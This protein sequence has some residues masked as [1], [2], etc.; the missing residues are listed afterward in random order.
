VGVF[1]KISIGVLKLFL[2][3][4]HPDSM[5]GDYEEEYLE[6]KRERGAFH[7]I[8]WL[9][10]EIIYLIPNYFNNS[11]FWSLVMLRNYLKIALRIIMRQKVYSF[12]NISGLAVGLASCILIMLWVQNELSFDRF[13]E[14]SENTYIIYNY[15]TYSDGA[16]DYW[17]QSPAP[18]KENLKKDFPE[19]S[20]IV[21][22]RRNGAVLRYND[23][24][25]KESNLQFVDAGFF[26]L[27]SF[28]LIQGD[29]E[30]CLLDPHSIVLT[31][32]MAEKYFGTENPIGK[33]VRLNDEL[34]LTVTGVAEECPSNSSIKF[35]FLVPFV[36]LKQLG[37][38]LESWGNW[39]YFYYVNIDENV[40]KAE[41]KEKIHHYY[42]QVFANQRDSNPPY[43][44]FMPFKD[45]YLYSSHILGGWIKGDVTYIYIFSAIA[46]FILLTACINFMNLATARSVNRAREVGLRKVVGAKRINVISQF[47][48]ESSFVALL[49]LILSFGIVAISLPFFNDLTSKELSF[50]M[51]LK[52]NI[53][54]VLFIT[55]TITSIISG[56]YPAIFLSSFQ[57][58]K[59][60]KGSLKAGAGNSLFRKVL[61]SLQFVLTIG[62]I[63]GAIVINQQLRFVRT[64]NMG[65]EKEHLITISIPRN[66]RSSLEALKN[67]FSQLTGVKNMT[68]TSSFPSGGMSS[69]S[70]FDWE[71]RT[72]DEE[73]NCFIL[74][75]DKEYAKTFGLEIVDG[76]F[77]SEE[78]TADSVGSL[79]VNETFV[80]ATGM[81]NPLGKMVAGDRLVGI[82][83]DYHFQSLHEPIAPLMIANVEDYDFIVLK[84]HPTSILNTIAG[85][86]AIWKEKTNDS[87]FEYEFLDER[88]NN[89]YKNDEKVEATINVFTILILF[90]ASLGLFGLSSF[91]AEQ[92]RKEVGIRKVMGASVSGLFF[93]MVRDYAKWIVLANVI[94]WPTAYFL[95]SKWLEGFAYRIDIPLIVFPLAG[96]L[97]LLIAVFSVGYQSISAATS[98][99]IDSIKY[100]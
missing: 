38:D 26:S 20:E 85:L 49:S 36:T 7:A 19:F 42:K 63:I 58:V 59:V 50:N 29:Q 90:V 72:A 71:G 39:G 21:R 40:N 83:K 98:N 48:G 11:F 16:D 75:T 35:E 89:M 3:N 45:A 33:I 24:V 1:G 74:Q 18:L 76:R 30:R 6:V 28:K 92:R 91:T 53:L 84:L 10:K 12:I 22:I 17:A 96:L 60:L 68:F 54:I 64:Q 13:H 32:K 77:F 65:F 88:I 86:E 37:N 100:E 61:V 82:V 73:I 94:A 8:F 52:P 80:K 97:A 9:W 2:N 15:E 25:F 14:K 23:K 57:P 66:V 41:L 27:F 55:F 56:S 99:P 5:V 62:L 34:N 79:V 51:I 4:H 78:F 81:E 70:G 46:L 44:S 87:P 69:S 93:L 31:E 43:T 67:E 47:Y 95:M